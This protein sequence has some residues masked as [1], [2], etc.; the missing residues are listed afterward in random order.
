M[1]S[2]QTE[3]VKAIL[4]QHGP[5]KSPPSPPI[6]PYIPLTS[7]DELL[8]NAAGQGN[9]DTVKKLITE[10]ANVNFQVCFLSEEI[11]LNHNF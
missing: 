9:L 2:A 6:I 11:K 10:G 3:E 7:K 4:K 5:I 8:L 1:K